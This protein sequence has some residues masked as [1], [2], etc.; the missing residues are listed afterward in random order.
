MIG[1]ADV[2]ADTSTEHPYERGGRLGEKSAEREGDSF[3]AWYPALT[4]WAKLWRA[5]GAGVVPTQISEF[6]SDH[7]PMLLQVKSD[8]KS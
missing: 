3:G 2:G 1:E 8:E 5:Y 4:R 7:A 6:L